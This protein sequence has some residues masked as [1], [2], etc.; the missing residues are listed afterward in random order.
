MI[1]NFN[2]VVPAL[3]AVAVAT[4]ALSQTKEADQKYCNELVQ[5]YREQRGHWMQGNI[6]RSLE[7]T[8]AIEACRSGDAASAIPTLEKY[9]RVEKVGPPAR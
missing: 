2:W 1:K 5:A 3:I 4:P 8:R 7:L 6:P 9:L